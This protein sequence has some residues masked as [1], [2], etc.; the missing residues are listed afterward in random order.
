MKNLVHGNVTFLRVRLSRES[1]WPE[2][3]TSD[4]G[5]ARNQKIG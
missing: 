5:K 1:M 2:I 3:L 4:L